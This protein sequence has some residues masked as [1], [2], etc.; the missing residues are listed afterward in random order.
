MTK[1]VDFVLVWCCFG[2]R[3]GN[4]SFNINC[5]VLWRSSSVCQSSAYIPVAHVSFM[6]GISY[7]DGVS[8]PILFKFRYMF[9]YVHDTNLP[10]I[11][12]S[13][14]CLLKQHFLHTFLH[15]LDDII[16]VKVNVAAPY[17]ITE[18]HTDWIP[19]SLKLL[20][21]CFWMHLPAPRM[22]PMPKLS[23]LKI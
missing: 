21:F 9:Y 4:N 17:F 8:C 2:A 13:W 22:L 3:W 5:P 11:S 7:T 20:G 23:S 12:S 10:C 15:Y 6:I 16:L 14:F 19:F 18:A 1:S